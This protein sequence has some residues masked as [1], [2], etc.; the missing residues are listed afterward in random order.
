MTTSGQLWMP[1]TR[2]RRARRSLGAVGL[3]MLIAACAAPTP[4]NPPANSTPAT[5]SAPGSSLGVATAPDLAAILDTTQTP[6]DL[7]V[8]PETGNTVTATIPATG[9][10]MTA[11]A[12][13]GTVYTLSIPNDALLVDTDI[14]MTPVA[15]VQGLPTSGEQTHAVQLGPDGLQLEDFATLTISPPTDLP[16]DQRIPF[17]YERSG[18]GMFLA[19]PALKEPRIQLR[20]LHFSGYGVTKGL[21]ASL[22]PVMQQF[23]GDA[24]ARI[25]SLIAARM[26]AEGALERAGHDVPGDYYSGLE[27]LLDAYEKDVV[28]KLVAAADKSCANAQ[29]AWLSLLTLARQR[30]MIGLPSTSPFDTE[31]P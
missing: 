27:A 1:V 25:S 30:Q 9:G 2:R 28:E 16:V 13:D 19:F 10:E 7:T 29:L 23:G 31:V 20:I 5:S 22:D 26:A 6:I 8:T 18:Q 11:T 4:S 17:G 15:S 14:S 24:D 12:A 3:A 21:L